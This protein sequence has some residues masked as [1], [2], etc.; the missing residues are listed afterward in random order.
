M[1]I[2]TEK[3]QKGRL[4]DGVDTI[5]SLSEEQFNIVLKKLIP[6]GKKLEKISFYYVTDMCEH[7]DNEICIG[8]ENENSRFY[9]GGKSFSISQILQYMA[10]K[11]ITIPEGTEEYERIEKLLATRNLEAFKS[12]YKNN[13]D[14][15]HAVIID[16]I[17]DILGDSETFEK[18]IDYNNNQDMFAIKGRKIELEEYLK[19]LG[20]FFGN[21]DENGN[22]CNQMTILRDFYIP[23][24]NIYKQRYLELFNRVNIDRYV[25]PTYEFKAFT[26][27]E[28]YTDEI[29]RKNE[30]P[31]WKINP[32]LYREVYKDKPDDLSL[33]EEAIYIYGKLC[34]LFSY[35][36]GYFYRGK[37]KDGKYEP[38]FSRE[39]L[40]SIAPGA[41]ITCW[42]FARIFS[43]FINDMDGNIEAV[44]ISQGA[45]QGHFL[46]GFYTD[47]VSVMLEPINGTNNDL[48][49]A[50]NGIR[51]GGIEIISDRE[52]IIEKALD[53][54]CPKAFGENQLCLAE[55]LENLRSTPRANVPNS[56]E[57]KIHAFIETM[58]AKE[59]SGN[60]LV[61]TFVDFNNSGFFE[62]KLEKSYLGRKEEKDGKSYYKRNILLR[63]NREYQNKGRDCKLYLLDT[64]SLELSTCSMQ[65]I[66]ERMISGELVYEDKEKI[67]RGIEVGEK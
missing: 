54:V 15:E 61:Q 51:L 50:K 53:T 33:E 28:H 63:I 47:R 11:M 45:K 37:T 24:I 58:K 25:N 41:K 6:K 64:S 62:E 7:P 56:T 67:M 66:E 52:G 38:D 55:Y 29:I 26:S 44:I 27:L 14:E 20:E 8:L 30:E 42:D 39:H 23:N 65:E 2:V 40:E 18:F 3:E 34:K 21:K 1:N 36:E 57:H 16:R 60:E 4:E 48:M 46:C 5:L 43:K 9:Y 31:E 10:E 13:A 17:F 19:Y 12:I 59:I 49:R 32:E 35:D 22:I